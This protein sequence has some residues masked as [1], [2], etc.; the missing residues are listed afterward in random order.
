MENSYVHHFSDHKFHDL[1]LCFCGYAQCEPLHSF[2]PA[3]RPCYLLHYILAGKGRY[4]VG[5]TQYELQAGQGFLIEPEVLTFYQ[6][7]QDNPW[8]YLWIGFDGDYAKEYLSDLGLNSSQLTFYCS[9]SDELK[10]IVHT[11]LQNNTASNKNQFLLE[12]LLYS[13]FS[14]LA[15]DTVV[16][17]SLESEHDNLYVRKA[18]EY[19]QNNYSNNIH[20]TDIADYVSIDRSYLY[21][22]FRQTMDMSPQDYLSYYRITRASELLLISDFPIGGIALSCGYQDRLAFTRAFKQ[23]MGVTPSQYRK[24]ILEKSKEHCPENI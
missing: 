18:V 10:H 1:R 3:V 21:L 15:Q 6:A 17:A 13:F 12:S 2:G 16:T 9:H 14:I 22:L 23:R 8:T 24:Q 4:Y 7:D 5:D 11:M 20:I 19:I